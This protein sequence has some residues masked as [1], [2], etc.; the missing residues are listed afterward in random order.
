MAKQE[1]ITLINTAT[2]VIFID[3]EMLKPG[4]HIDIEQSE[5]ERFE[6]TIGRGDLT[7]DNFNKNQEVVTKVASKRKK[8]PSEG[9]TRAELEDGGE[10]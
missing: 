10:F 8:D 1:K 2:C 7:I 6:S 4:D 3:G 9:K 5:I